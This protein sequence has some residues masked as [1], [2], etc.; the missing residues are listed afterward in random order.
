MDQNMVGFQ[1]EIGTRL[2][3][4]PRKAIKDY[5]YFFRGLRVE[6]E[7]LVAA[8]NVLD[9]QIVL[10]ASDRRA[11]QIAKGELDCLEAIEDSELDDRDKCA[12]ILALLQGALLRRSH[13]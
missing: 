1:E 6:P 5:N 12:E 10:R 11:E 8:M 2:A 13:K 9:D 3:E 7:E 4:Y